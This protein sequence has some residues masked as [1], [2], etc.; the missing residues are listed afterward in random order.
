[1]LR[2]AL[3]LLLAGAALAAIWAFVP[4]GGRTLADRW[5]TARN[6]SEFID[7]T[8]AEMKG[9]GPADGKEKA[10]PSSPGR[11][12]PAQARGARPSGRPPT[13]SHSE[14]DRRALD[15]LLSERLED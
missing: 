2:L 11:S 5:S 4:F 12:K 1:M 6:P 14:A 10:K 9:E 13:E 3:K 7:R 15:R 8:W